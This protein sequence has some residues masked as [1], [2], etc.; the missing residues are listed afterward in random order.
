MEEEIKEVFAEVN[1]QIKELPRYDIAKMAI[2]NSKLIYVESNEVALN[3]INEYAPEHFVC[4][5][6]HQI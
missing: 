1:K 4:R 3:L 2:D 6:C 5:A